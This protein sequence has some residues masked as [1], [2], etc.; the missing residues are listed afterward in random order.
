MSPIIESAKRTGR[1]LVVQE[2][3]ESQGLGHEIIS[4]IVSEGVRLSRPPSLL[5]RPNLPVPFAP[6]LEMQ[7][8][9][10]TGKILAAVECMCETK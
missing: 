3:G 5:A 9:P 6:E 8:R 10:D 2:S 4:R 1:L 7:C